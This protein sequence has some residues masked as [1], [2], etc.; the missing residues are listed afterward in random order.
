[1]P[2]KCNVTIFSM[3]GTIVRRF[4]RD[5]TADNTDGGQLNSKTTNLDTSIDWDMKNEK[6]VPVASGMYII[7]I[8][9]GELGEKTLKWLGIMR[10]IDLD[11][12]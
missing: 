7:H 1:L 3:D 5:V 2:A 10:P 8:D 9:A 6:N 4:T 12:F 11:S